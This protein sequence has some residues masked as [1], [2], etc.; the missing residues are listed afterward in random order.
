MSIN[1]SDPYALI[2]IPIVWFPVCL[3]YKASHYHAL[4]KKIVLLARLI[5]LLLLVLA[6]A[7]AELRFTVDQQSVVF[8]VDVSASCEKAREKAEDFIKEALKHKEVEEQAAIVVFGENARV[9]QPMLDNLQFN[10]IETVIGRQQ[11]NIENSIILGSGLLPDGLRKRIVLLSDGNENCGDAWQETGGLARKNIRLDVVPL[12]VKDGPDIRIDSLQVPQKLYAKERFS[13]QTRVYSNIDTTAVLRF[14]RDDQVIIEDTV[15]VTSGENLFVYSSAISES[16]FYTFKVVGEMGSH[17]TVPENNQAGAFTVVQGTPKVLVVEGQ[18][19]E[20]R[21]IINAIQSSGI[22]T[23]LTTPANLPLTPQ[24]L[25]AYGLVILCNV[26]AESIPKQA[27]EA[28]HSSVRDLGMGLVMVGGENSYGPG[29]YYQTPVE[30]ALP[31]YMDLRGKAEIPSLGLVLVIDKSGSMGEQAG[32]YSKIA[33]ARE[34]AIQATSILSPYDQVGVIAFDSS[35]A[36]VVETQKVEDLES[37]QG[38]IASIQAGGGTNIFPALQVAYS[39]LK[40]VETKY[41]HIILLTDGQS[42]TSGDYYYL[43]KRMQQSGITMSTVAVGDGADIL[44]MQQLAE[45]GGGRYYFTNDAQNVPW[46]FTKE[47]MKALRHYL[48]EEE[49]YPG[50]SSSSPLIDGIHEA[51]PLEGYVATTPKG[52][53]QVVLSSHLNDPVLAG[54]QYGLGRSVAFTTDSGGKWSGN[55]IRWPGYNQIWSNIVS[56]VLPRVDENHPLSLRSYMDN[57]LGIIEVE[58]VDTGRVVPT[59]ASIVGPDLENMQV[60]LDPAGPG[61]YQAR[62]KVSEPGAYLI[63]IR[64]EVEEGFR[65][66]NGGLIVPYSSEYKS[67]GTNYP[68]LE[69]LAHSTGG[70]IIDDPAQVFADNLAPVKGAVKLWP[71]FL[72]AALLL[73]LADIAA[74]RINFRLDSLSRVWQKKTREPEY[75]DSTTSRL[76]RRKSELKD[77]QDIKHQRSEPAPTPDS[78]GGLSDRPEPIPL[79]KESKEAPTNEETT[80]RL[81]RRVSKKSNNY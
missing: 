10:R 35:A 22:E 4:R 49:F 62:F 17:D 2:L 69:Q 15:N 57:S 14:Y 46:I 13:I 34:A 12:E 43:A 8:V 60:S 26:P 25:S 71:W 20:G 11:T 78:T 5:I 24:K 66:I 51:P 50:I 75:Q 59:F 21:S 37:I 16:G 77:W 44:L 80:K 67:P 72:T 61:K 36:W 65:M 55:W 29:G 33:L 70:T 23:E 73:F 68:F 63:N 47:T 38:S 41:K 76:N 56:W 42:A 79:G 19:G 58:S 31:V 81:L 39:S 45:W 48:V 64:Q 9:E 53:A 1:F 27:M 3:W 52:T 18:Q 7:G 6:L 32:G 74:R 54:W 40:D 28:I 30:K